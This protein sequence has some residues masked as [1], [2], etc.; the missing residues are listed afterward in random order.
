M[1]KE[2]TVWIKPLDLPWEQVG[3]GQFGCVQA[4]HFL[5]EFDVHAQ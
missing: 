5:L 2:T 3:T 4:G 1:A